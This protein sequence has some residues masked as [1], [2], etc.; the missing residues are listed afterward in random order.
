LSICCPVKIIGKFPATLQG[1]AVNGALTPPPGHPSVAIVIQKA[2]K[3]LSIN[4]EVRGCSHPAAFSPGERI[5]H[6]VVL[7]NNEISALQKKYFT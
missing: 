3:I 2:E 6:T 5:T 4:G 7:E 1:F